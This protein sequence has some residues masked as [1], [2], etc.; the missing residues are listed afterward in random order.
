[1]AKTVLVV[2]DSTSMRQM[3]T[4]TLEE[5]GFTVIQGVNGKDALDKIGA[6]TL[7]LVITDLK[8]PVMD[9]F[10]FLRNFRARPGCKGTPVLVLTTESQIEKSR[11]PMPPERPVGF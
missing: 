4:F 10:A 8:M 7:D 9:G 3:V 6:H 1:M 2:D 11:K 5:G